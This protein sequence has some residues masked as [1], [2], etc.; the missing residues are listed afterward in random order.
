MKEYNNLLKKFIKKKYQ[1][2]TVYKNEFLNTFH[3]HRKKNLN[4]IIKKKITFDKVNKND[5][6]YK[7]INNLYNSKHNKNIDNN[8]IIFYKKFEIN[9]SLKKKY[10][11][12]YKKNTNTETCL[13]TYVF[14]GL[15]IYKNKILNKFQKINCILK[16]L[17][18]ILINK[19]NINCCNYYYLSL[20]ISIE[21]KIIYNLIYDK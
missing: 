20:L 11:K 2:S 19:R 10:N 16:I 1:R 12:Y 15:M 17:D 3:L 18:K 6:T 14:L 21:K 8:I 5:S 4:Y 13:A 9:L 7:V